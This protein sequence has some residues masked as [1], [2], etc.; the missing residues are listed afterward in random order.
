MFQKRQPS[1]TTG[2]AVALATAAAVAV[3]GLSLGAGDAQALRLP[4]GQKKSTGIDG[5]VVTLKR[6][7]EHVFAQPS[8]ARNGFG[9]SARVSGIYS[10][11]VNRGGGNV[12]VGYLV[13]CQVN[14]GGLDMGLSAGISGI[15]GG[16]SPLINGT[17]SFPLQPGQ[18]QVVQALNKNFYKKVV[19]LQL[20]GVE[21]TVQSCGGFAQAR[22]FIK[23]LATENPSSENGTFSGNSG[24]IQST[25][26]G[27]PFSLA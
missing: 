1:R 2:V 4:S 17:V 23:V 19:N 27:K 3:S 21:I 10:A 22:S 13:G 8:E 18:I 24:A 12:Q 20:S 26:Y 6:S 16:V 5:Q 11:R 15:S 25:L 14:V 7:H 9:R